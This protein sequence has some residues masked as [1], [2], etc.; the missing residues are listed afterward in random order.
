M[1]WTCGHTSIA[2]FEPLLGNMKR[3]LRKD[4]VK[5]TGNLPLNLSP[6]QNQGH[7]NPTLE[8]VSGA[9]VAG[10]I[11]QPARAA[12]DQDEVGPLTPP[13]STPGMATAEMRGPPQAHHA[14][15]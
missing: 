9:I 10:I 2:Q 6:W 7:E 8:Q 15:R 5:Q 3:R 12:E 4:R 13:P 1:L 14:S 11:Q